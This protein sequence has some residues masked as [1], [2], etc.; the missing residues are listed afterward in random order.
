MEA[1]IAAS[2]LSHDS[3]IDGAIFGMRRLELP[4]KVEAWPKKI[5]SAVDHK[6][7]EE[8]WMKRFHRL[9]PFSVL[10]NMRA[11]VGNVPGVEADGGRI[12]AT[13]EVRRL[14]L[15]GLHELVAPC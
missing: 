8:S 10:S 5:E 13:E 11:S 12:H 15:L 9:S 14:L 3:H 7:G 4:I 2:Y 1:L 6:S